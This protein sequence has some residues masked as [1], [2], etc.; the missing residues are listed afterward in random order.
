MPLIHLRFRCS[1][2]GSDRTDS[3]I[4]SKGAAAV[5]PW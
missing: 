5:Q 4:T 1:N 3:V 2:Y